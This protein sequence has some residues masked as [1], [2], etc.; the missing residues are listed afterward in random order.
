[1]PFSGPFFAAQQLQLSLSGR[2]WVLSSAREGLIGQNKEGIASLAGAPLLS[3][4]R[5]GARV[6]DGV[7]RCLS[8]RL[9]INLP[10]GPSNGRS[11]Y[12]PEPHRVFH[13]FRYYPLGTLRLDRSDDRA[14]IK[15]NSESLLNVVGPSRAD[16]EGYFI[17]ALGGR[18]MHPTRY[19]SPHITR[20]FSWLMQSS[21]GSVVGGR[22]IHRS[23]LKRSTRM[24][25]PFSSW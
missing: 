9:R 5:E 7:L 3:K 4:K 8:S 24:G 19:G 6:T 14:G 10:D 23:Y 18:Q 11:I 21:A 13:I 17:S 20:P 25:W 16:F 22:A 2:D 12:R 15:A 1:M